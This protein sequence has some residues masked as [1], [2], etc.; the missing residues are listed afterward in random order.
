MPVHEHEKQGG[1]YF[2]GQCAMYSL[3]NGHKVKLMYKQNQLDEK[4]FPDLETAF[5]ER[6]FQKVDF[7]DLLTTV[8][9]GG[10]ISLTG[11]RFHNASSY[12]LKTIQSVFMPRQRNLVHALMVI[13]FSKEGNVTY[14]RSPI[15]KKAC[16]PASN[17]GK[18]AN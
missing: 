8:A 18:K 17:A 4:I 15:P 10:T 6:S 14:G 11:P 3:P 5:D 1:D 12:D 9:V 13:V 2:L 7:W 16:L